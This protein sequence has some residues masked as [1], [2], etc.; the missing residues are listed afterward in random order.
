MFD[1]NAQ[2]RL[3]TAPNIWLATVR[4]DGSPHLIPIWFVWIENKLYVCTARNSVKARNVAANPKVSLA[5]EDGSNPL[6]LEGSG[7]IREETP[8]EVAAEFQR[9]YNW[10]IL[11]DAT[12]NVLIEITPSRRL[13]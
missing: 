4:P 12:Y 9:K 13:L 1:S 6:V 8:P 11:G 2:Q 7:A 5:L 10:N 3:Q